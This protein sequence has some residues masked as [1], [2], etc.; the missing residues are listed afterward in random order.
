M[1][2]SRLKPLSFVIA[3]LFSAAAQSEPV[4]LKKFEV[5]PALLAPPAGKREAAP[6]SA[7]PASPSAP[8]AEETV[9]QRSEP[10]RESA[11]PPVVA[12]PA[13]I[14]ARET[15]RPSAI[16]EAPARAAPAETAPS[17]PPPQVPVPPE[18]LGA[19][20]EL[21]TLGTG[22]PLAL[23]FQPEFLP[24]PGDPKIPLP[25]FIS[26]QRLQG[27]PDKQV[28]AVGEA[29]LRRLGYRVFAERMSYFPESSEVSAAG[30]V[31]LEQ[32]GDVLEGPALRLNLDTERGHMEKPR[33]SLIET[34]G[35]G[36]GE[37]L[38]FEGENKFRMQKASYTTC[39][40]DQEDWYLKVGDLEIDRNR[41]VG[42]ARNASV[43][44]KDVPL[45]YMP[46]MDF[47]L[48]QTRKS[49]LL[50]PVFGSTTEGGAELTLPYYWNIAPNLDATLAPRVMTKRGL[51]LNNELRYL[52]PRYRGI[53]HADALPNDRITRRSRYGLSLLHTQDFTRGWSGSL[54]LQKV[55]DD[56]YFRDL[57]NTLA[58]TSQTHLQRMG[59]LGYIGTWWDGAPWSAQAK[60][61]RWQTLQDPKAP[62]LP[63]YSRA[64]QLYVGGSKPGFRGADFDAYGS[65]VDFSHPTLVSGTR[66]VA[67]PSVSYPLYTAFGTL[68]PKLG[69]HYTRYKLD[70]STTTPN[71]DA[72]RTLPIF[73]LNAGTVFER[74]ISLGGEAFLQTLEPRAYYVYIPFRNQSRLPVFDT[75]ETDFNFA[76]IFTEN[77]FGGEDRI[78]DANQVTLALTS[79]LL[80]P[81]GNERLRL[82]FGQRI[83]LTSQRV[84]LTAPAA[85][86]NR[87]DFLAA[88]TGRITSAW[89]LDAGL[90]YNPEDQVNEKL[91]LTAR[92]RPEPNKVANFSYRNTRKTLEQ[93]DASAQWPL[94]SR[95]Y[96]VGRMNYSLPDSRI[97]EG[98]AGL[99]Y[100]AG[101][102]VLRLVAQRFVTATQ[103][104]ANAVF[105]QLELNGLA[106]IGA[107]PMEVLRKAIPGYT[108]IN[109]PENVERPILT[110][111]SPDG[112]VY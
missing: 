20:L 81:D 82:A 57:S 58:A 8:R 105:L 68:T 17:G 30:H 18:P 71:T 59:A 64:P 108:K 1:S 75:G 86:R 24:F 98:L 95:W 104:T 76:Q 102:W 2:E 16:F 4:G 38:L 72:T 111:P 83:N 87:S 80:Q 25:I 94:S 51:M 3:C 65:F 106:N 43:W 85:R 56:D 61:Q 27:V 103:E 35:R 93:V 90:Q 39:P 48:N 62:V 92:Y 74:D 40:A 14:Q 49:G 12:P 73:S 88:L 110:A 60:I 29:E 22:V 66:T 31:K 44:F 91:N 13:S 32:R 107:D 52:E 78:N 37:R 63:P 79:R 15:P 26:A 54:N 55:S 7:R 112:R 46:W 53:V 100:N 77:R 101:C 34:G 23:K 41:Q 6:E 97:L 99:E 45:L 96:G 89:Q 28:D 42:V 5:D 11:P 19:P 36:S 84:F 47:S 67:Y 70:S 10:V 9:L 69:L 21:E 50:A 109:L 33:M